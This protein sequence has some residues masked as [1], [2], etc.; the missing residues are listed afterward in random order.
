MELL[1]GPF[2]RCGE[3][4]TIIQ[5][6]LGESE[7]NRK[8]LA[9]STSDSLLPLITSPTIPLQN[10]CALPNVLVENASEWHTDDIK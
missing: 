2:C 6:A 1:R 3:A 8:R 10:R 9:S 5:F 7:L 4:Q